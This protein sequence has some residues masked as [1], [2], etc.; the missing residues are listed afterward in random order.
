MMMP[1]DA[2]VAKPETYGLAEG[3]TGATQGMMTLV[4][5]LPPDRYEEVMRRIREHDTRPEPK[6]TTPAPEEHGA[7]GHR[8]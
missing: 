7:P 5:V 4:R 1:M 6:P 3:W 8:H 2:E